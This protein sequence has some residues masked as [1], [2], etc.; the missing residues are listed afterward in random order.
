[1]TRRPKAKLLL[2]ALVASAG[3]CKEPVPEVVRELAASHA[4]SDVRA[5]WRFRV[6][7]TT[8]YYAQSECC[9]RVNV[10]YDQDG[11]V[12]C[13]PDGGIA[14]I[15]DGKCP[16]FLKKA[17]RGVLIWEVGKDVPSD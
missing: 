8:V 3:A 16:D 1:M 13:A 14:G 17:S 9:D 10:L 5:I 4:A 12:I 2:L 15:G 6:N 11:A 7:G